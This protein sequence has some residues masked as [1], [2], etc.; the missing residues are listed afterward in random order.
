MKTNAD[1]N[2]LIWGT[3]N[4]PST[5][6]ALRYYQKNISP[7][8]TGADILNKIKEKE[9]IIGRPLVNLNQTVFLS[10]KQE[11]YFIIEKNN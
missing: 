11:R 5:N 8:Y 1:L 6:A 3:C 4:F 10:E 9:I 2:K 7:D